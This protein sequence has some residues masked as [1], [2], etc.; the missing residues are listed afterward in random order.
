MKRNIMVIANPKSGKSDN[1]KYEEIIKSELVEYFDD[2]K[3]EYTEDK[4]H[5][6]EL[7]IK[8]GNEGYDSVCS[9]GGD[10]TLAEVL[11][12]LLKL[13]NPPKLL[14]FPGG[15]GNI[16]S[17][18]LGYSQNKQ[19]VFSNIDF[20]NARPIDIGQANGHAFGF[21]LSIGSVP[22]SINEVSNEDKDKFG[23]FAYISSIFKTIGHEKE[24][25]LRVEVDDQIYEGRV[26]HLGVSV[27]EKFGPFKVNNLDAD[28]NDGL[29]H[30]FIL[31]DKSLLKKAKI[32][33]DSIFGN[34]TKN[35]SIEYFS[36]KDI[37][38]TSLVDECVHVDL[39]GDKGPKLPLQITVVHDK[40]KVYVP[41]SK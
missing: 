40:V 3:I 30:V 31:K 24:Y 12:G 35:E 32:G 36:G 41:K 22:E 37:K 11:N 4:G 13:E 26:D 23:F 10:G 38:I 8:A 17:Q 20:E 14:I 9:M 28:Y 27:S 7:A 39:D 21:L 6:T 5:A 34:V 29:L 1:D 19:R 15:T 2:I 16:M 25:N 18:A 33:M